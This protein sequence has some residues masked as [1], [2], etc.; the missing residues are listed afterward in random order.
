MSADTNHA[1]LPKWLGVVFACVTAAGLVVSITVYLTTSS[2]PFWRELLDG[3]WAGPAETVTFETPLELLVT[4]SLAVLYGV[5]PKLVFWVPALGLC[6]STYLLMH[7]AF[8]RA[9]MSTRLSV[10]W[11]LALCGFVL[12]GP[13]ACTVA[14]V[15][16]LRGFQFFV[17]P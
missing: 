14:G 10:L 16:T 12:G 17:V 4:A 11:I 15:Q 1:L 6:A 2:F 9:K 8:A 13:A 3:S 5:L 7:W